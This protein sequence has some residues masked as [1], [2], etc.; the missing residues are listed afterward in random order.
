MLHGP[1]ACE[2][3]TAGYLIVNK[4]PHISISLYTRDTVST[5]FLTEHCYVDGHRL[6]VMMEQSVTQSNFK[7][8]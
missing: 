1:S 4:G 2:V 7:G 5:I 6:H 3:K 8:N